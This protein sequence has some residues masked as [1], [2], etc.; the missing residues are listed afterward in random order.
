[1]RPQ[2]YYLNQTQAIALDAELMNA[3]L[4]GF[5]IDT[6]M[7]L[8][9]LSVACVV[10][11]VYPQARRVL[12]L[13]GPGNNG[14]DALVA[15]RH[16]HHFGFTPEIYYPK[17]N[18]NVPL[19]ANLQ[20]QLNNLRVPF[21]ETLPTNI[22]ERYDLILDGIFG[23]SFDSKSPI[24]PPFDEILR[25]LRRTSTE[26]DEGTPIASIDIPSGWD[27]DE[28]DVNGVGVKMPDTLISLTAPKPCARKF[29]GRHHYLGGR[30]LPAEMAERYDLRGLPAYKGWDQFVELDNTMTTTNSGDASEKASHDDNKRACSDDASS[31]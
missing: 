8:A 15:S 17:R 20:T 25:R 23:F 2:H 24:R 5:S 1:M 22:G 7:E 29:T 11:K 6:L 3:R 18:P 12:A 9:G 10:A 27:C 28:G 16:L 21:I 13:V 30:F 31:L 26:N 14:G 19:F 4:G